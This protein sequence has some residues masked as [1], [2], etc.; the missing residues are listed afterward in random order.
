MILQMEAHNRGQ[1][2][3][4]LCRGSGCTLERGGVHSP[5]GLAGA[6]PAAAHGSPAQVWSL[7]AFSCCVSLTLLHKMHLVHSYPDGV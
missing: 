4:P 6:R 7:F 2:D 3:L 5:R 1:T